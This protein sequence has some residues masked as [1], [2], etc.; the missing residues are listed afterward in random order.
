M[1]I[2]ALKIF[3]IKVF[4][5]ML[6][7]CCIAVTPGGEKF[8]K[9]SESSMISETKTISKLLLTIYNILANDIHSPNFLPNA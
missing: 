1:K 9:F 5:D 4:C 3:S 8:G 2:T 6:D 7:V